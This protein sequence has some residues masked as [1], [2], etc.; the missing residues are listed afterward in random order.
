MKRLRRWLATACA[1]AYVVA[2]ATAAEGGTAID[3]A[4][5][6]SV[7]DS[8][9]FDELLPA[10]GRETGIEVRLIVVGSGAALRLGADGDADALVTHDPKGELALVEEGALVDRR[11]VM[12]NFFLVAGPP[13]D[14]AGLRAARG[15]ADA[16]SRL[17]AAN[18]PYVSRGDDSG[19]HRRER[20]ILAAAGLDP[21]RGWPAVVRT[22]AGMGHTL[23]VAGERRAYVLADV[24]TFRAFEQRIELVAFTDPADPALVNVYSVSRPNPERHP[25][26]RLEVEGARRFAD[27]L[28]APA[29]Q[30]RIG[31]FGADAEGR[32]L[33]TP[34]ARPAA[35]AG[36][37]P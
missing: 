34:L 20:E 31:A 13:E 12:S 37:T 3:V 10:F 30:A 36:T 24:G 18:A 29:T 16:F 8:G 2:A 33:F 15:A 28:V 9:L 1:V 26:G 21:A 4:T 32:A 5:T 6:T 22:S 14:P 17:A 19:T 11:P 35:G 25:A 27:F 7:R 23:Q